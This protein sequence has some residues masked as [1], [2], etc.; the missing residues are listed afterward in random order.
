MMKG[1]DNFF[2]IFS[3]KPPM[4]KVPEEGLFQTTGVV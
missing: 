4:A 1:F 2:S 3:A